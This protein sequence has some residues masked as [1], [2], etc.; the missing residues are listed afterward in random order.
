MLKVTDHRH[1]SS[2]IRQ[3]IM[4]LKAFV[5]WLILSNCSQVISSN[6]PNSSE[7]RSSFASEKQLSLLLNDVSPP[8]YR[9]DLL[10]YAVRIFCGIQAIF[11]NISIEFFVSQSTANYIIYMLSACSAC[12]ITING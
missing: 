1:S 8:D 10:D 7:I 3:F 4:K 6:L 12:G 11:L 5:I 9:I 2:F